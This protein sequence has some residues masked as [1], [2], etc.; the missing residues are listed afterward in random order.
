MK[1]GRF[2]N[3]AYLRTLASKQA[4][5][6][7]TRRLIRD[8]KDMEDNDI[9]TVNVSASPLEDDLFTW[10]ANLIGPKDT[11]YEGSMYHLEIKI[12]ETYPMMPPTISFMSPIHHPNAFVNPDGR[13]YRLCLDLTEVNKAAGSGGWSSAYSIQSILIQLQSFLIEGSEKYRSQKAAKKDT[14]IDKIQEYNEAANDFKC[15]CCKHK[16][17]G[18]PFPK[19]KR[20]EEFKP[21]EDFKTVKSEETLYQDSLRCFHSKLGIDETHLGIGLKVTTI[22]RNGEINQCQ[23]ILDYISLK[24]FYKNGIR[25]SVTNETFGYWMPLYFKKDQKDKTLALAKKAL[26]F[27]CTNNSH[28]FEQKMVAKVMLKCISTTIM[29]II[30]QKRHPSILIIRHL[31][32]FHTLLLLFVR[33]YPEIVKEFDHEIEKFI[34]SEDNRIKK[35]CPNLALIMVY[36]LFSEKYKFENVVASLNEEQLDRQV[37]WIL[38]KIPELEDDSGTITVD[39]NRVRVTFSSQIMGYL[40]VCFYHDYIKILRNKFKTWLNMLDYMENHCC[41][42]DDKTEN[43]IQQ[44]FFDCEDNIKDYKDYYTHIGMPVKDFEDICKRLKEAVKNSKRKKYH[45][46]IDELLGLPSN[47][48]QIKSFE[49]K[50]E[51]LANFIKDGKLATFTDDQWREKCLKRWPWMRRYISF[52]FETPLLPKDIAEHVDEFNYDYS[53]VCEDHIDVTKACR[54]R[55]NFK[56]AQRHRPNL[57]QLYSTNFSWRELFIKLDF[58]ENTRTLNFSED[59]KSFYAKVQV[60]AEHLSTVVVYISK[61][62]NLKSGYYYLAHLLTHLKKVKAL[63]IRTCCVQSVPYKA[64]NNI[65]KGLSISNESKDASSIEY[66]EINNIQFDLSA[67][68]QECIYQIFELMPNLNAIKINNSNVLQAKA[69]K[70]I[71]SILTNHPEMKEITLDKAI[72]NETIGK[73]LADGL[74][75]TKKLESI[76]VVNNLSSAGNSVTNILYNLSFAPRVT[77]VDCSNNTPNNFNDYIENLGKMISINGSIEYLILNNVLGIM[78]NVNLEFFKHLAENQ[79][80]KVLSLENSKTLNSTIN[81]QNIVY[82]GQALA[83]NA[84]K[85]GKLRELYLGGGVLSNFSNLDQ[86]CNSTYFSNQLLEQWYGDSTKASKM[87]GQDLTYNYLCN[88]EVLDLSKTIFSGSFSYEKFNK[89][90]TRHLPAWTRIF[91]VFSNLTDLNLAYCS[92]NQTFCEILRA[93]YEEGVP[94]GYETTGI[95]LKVASKIKVL[96][97]EHNPILKEGAKHLKEALKRMEHLQNLNLSHLKLGVSGAYSVNEV[98]AE[99]KTLKVV[100]LFCNKYD[101]DGARSLAKAIEKNTSLEYIDVGYNRIRDE[102]F[103]EIIKALKTNKGNKIKCL[104]LKNNYLRDPS[105]ELLMKH[106]EEKSTL[107][108]VIIKKN[109][110]SQYILNAARERYEKLGTEFY[111]DIYNKFDYNEEDKLKRS[112]WVH[113]FPANSIPQIYT[114][115]TKIDKNERQVGIVLNIRV[116]KGNDY[117]NRKK[118]EAHLFIEFAHELSVE[119]ALVLAS[120]KKFII[121]G[122]NLRV[123]RAG[124]STYFYSTHCRVK[125]SKTNFTKADQRAPRVRA[126]RG[127]RGGKK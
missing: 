2:Q 20:A 94:A 75:R 81:Y 1:G 97:L 47:P 88:L 90:I 87:G 74:M 56:T 38:K 122:I 101:V 49:S 31:L 102:G 96:N 93:L 107:R 123:F 121:N 71:T 4:Q 26:S 62:D 116:R 28:R 114:F 30:E 54:S 19:I 109:L 82:L 45:G 48:D 85:K 113:P 5:N 73:S 18:D 32:N 40:L 60:V 72:G 103:K 110:V 42:L 100:N 61:C 99:S 3:T 80:I 44:S 13:T 14:D 106:L 21:D 112:I 98:L 64:L 68:S 39:E 108:K 25:R 67:T 127:G 51:D 78:N 92:L 57:V 8:M 70:L 23:P 52:D 117:P 105:F 27:I 9:P 58:E 83:I 89:H 11:L 6:F 33:E 66:F 126:G 84:H 7:A 124:S 63:K 59:F 77:Y 35:N 115:L 111:V 55:F 50:R 104:G 53:L 15:P 86:L 16:G 76:T 41:K 125:N 79:S 34:S 118:G 119:K 69:S 37:F 24:S 91:R 36:L 22:A 17:R 43:E 95:N 65:K 12:P 29:K 120:K 10:H 46:S